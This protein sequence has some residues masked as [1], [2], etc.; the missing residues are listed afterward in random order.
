MLM[1]YFLRRCSTF[2]F[3]TAGYLSILY[4]YFSLCLSLFSCEL[5]VFV[6]CSMVCKN[7]RHQARGTF[8]PIFSSIAPSIN[9]LKWK[10]CF[11]FLYTYPCV[12]MYIC[13]F[14]RVLLL[15][16]IKYESWKS[17]RTQ[18]RLVYMR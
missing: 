13:H 3:L 12:S 18:K 9:S 5:A 15:C 7:A 16:K 4:I 11:K 8:M 17:T 6:H 14:L 1:V 2:S 10:M